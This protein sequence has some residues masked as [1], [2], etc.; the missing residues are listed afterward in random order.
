M[1]AQFS[2]SFCDLVK[3]NLAGR[4]KFSRKIQIF[5]IHDHQQWWCLVCACMAYG[6]KLQYFLFTLNVVWID[7][8][9]LHYNFNT[10]I[11][12][13]ISFIRHIVLSF[14]HMPHKLCCI[15]CL[16]QKNSGI[17]C[18]CGTFVLI[19]KPNINCNCFLFLNRY[20][21]NK[22]INIVPL[23]SSSSIQTQ[24]RENKVNCIEF[25]GKRINIFYFQTDWIVIENENN[26][27]RSIEWR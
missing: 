16:T 20:T 13:P 6:N 27:R 19:I 23:T 14:E 2:T 4:K 5:C 21:F 7:N 12:I 11:S 9:I 22:C 17:Q 18:E 8:S 15:N 10:Q 24:N 26:M 1:P 25:I 3:E